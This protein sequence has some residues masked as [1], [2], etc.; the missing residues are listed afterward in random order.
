MPDYLAFRQAY[1]NDLLHVGKGHDD[2]PPGRGSGR[3]PY[4]SGDRPFQRVKGKVRDFVK[5]TNYEKK[6]VGRLRT[7]VEAIGRSA[8]ASA[9]ASIGATAVGAGTQN[10]VVGMMSY[11]VLLAGLLASPIGR[12]NIYFKKPK[13]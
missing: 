13:N 1:R 6:E 7:G 9:L 2:N 4:G 5:A 3:Y 10:I 11:N 8:I 12:M